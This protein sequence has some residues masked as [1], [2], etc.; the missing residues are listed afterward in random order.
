MLSTLWGLIF[1]A[2]ETE[3]KLLLA[4]L[5]PGDREAVGR[6]RERERSQGDIDR[7][8]ENK[9]A[10]MARRVMALDKAG[11]LLSGIAITLGEME[12]L[13]RHG[14]LQPQGQ[15]LCEKGHRHAR[16]SPKVGLAQRWRQC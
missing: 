11:Q 12:I 7:D 4:A 10:E 14:M 8:W 5:A 16:H 6:A 15:A 9:F 1:H 3:G 2:S 13:A